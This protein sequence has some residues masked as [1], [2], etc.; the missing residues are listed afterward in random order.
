MKLS[1]LLY[2]S[3]LI[4]LFFSTGCASLTH[5][6]DSSPDLV[7]VPINDK[8][9][10]TVRHRLDVFAPRKTKEPAKVLMF[11]HG[12]N[13]ER[14]EKDIYKP[15]GKR[16]ARKGV[17]TVI[18]NYRLSPQAEYDDMMMDVAQSV[19]WVKDSISG[20]GGDPD[21]IFVSGHS[22][23]GHLASMI[24]IR[25]CYF[26][27][28]GIQ[29][30]IK[31][32]V[33]LDPGGLDMYTYLT[34]EK[35]PE[36]HTYLQTFTHDPENWIDASPKYHL[37]PNMPPMLI[38]VGGRTYPEILRSTEEFVVE[39]KKY[40]PSPMYKV[41]PMKRHI[42]M[43][44]QFFITINPRYKEILNFMEAPNHSP[45]GPAPAP[46]MISQQRAGEGD[47][48]NQEQVRGQIGSSLAPAPQSTIR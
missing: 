6:I 39:L 1:N 15:L 9:F 35:F 14:G 45:F 21:Q 32:T 11:I 23:G 10:D 36:D 41:L 20:F 17:V 12:G 16:I 38:Y 13:W 19:K 43:I 26:D 24:S 5:K 7:Y 46:E 44:A 4:F 31:G 3:I 47:S 28:L 37:H 18:I 40:V 34:E 42:P 30:P 2:T 48:E 29:N 33:L 27:S 25:N 8:S 22:A